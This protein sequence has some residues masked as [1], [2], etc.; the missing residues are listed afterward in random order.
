MRDKHPV[1]GM[2]LAG[3]QSRRMDGV[4]KAFL[5]LA[6]RNLIEHVAARA[7]TQVDQLLIGASGDP[8]RFSTL[9]AKV[10]DDAVPGF[11]GPLA[12]I[13]AGLLWTRKHRPDVA[14]LASFACDTPFFPADMV[15]RLV[16]AA[17]QKR[18]AIAVASSGGRSHPVFAV[19]NVGIVESAQTAIADEGVQKV[20]A[21]IERFPHT[22]VAWSSSA[23]TDPFFNIN[24][25]QD[26]AEAEARLKKAR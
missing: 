6:G 24:T 1:I 3:G 12:G 20:N 4:E 26:L 2:V 8:T 10:V 22:S 5:P 9:N 25:P 19:W 16:A 14:W 17:E 15:A 11:A 21:L 18:A 23:D 13:L 7:E